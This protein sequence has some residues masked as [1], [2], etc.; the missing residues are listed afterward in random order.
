MKSSQAGEVQQL[1][2][3]EPGSGGGSSAE[4]LLRLQGRPRAGQGQLQLGRCGGGVGGRRRGRRGEEGAEHQVLVPARPRR[5]RRHLNCR[6]SRRPREPRPGATGAAGAA[7]DPRAWRGGGRAAA[8]DAPA[9]GRAGR[10]AGPQERALWLADAEAA[11]P[12]RPV[13]DALDD[14]AVGPRGHL[15]TGSEVHCCCAGSSFLVLI[16]GSQS[17]LMSSFRLQ[18][19]HKVILHHPVGTHGSLG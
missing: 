14:G 8:A 10:H 9:D 18:R 17:Q 12:R 13:R 16:A 15:V 4:Q 5:R 19:H 2:R 1:L 11:L 3:T 6:G 7:R